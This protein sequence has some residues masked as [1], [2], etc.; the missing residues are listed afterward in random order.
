LQETAAETQNRVKTQRSQCP[1]ATALDIFG[2]RWTLVLV[3]DLAMG[4]GKARFGDFL[5]SPERIPTNILTE[6][7]ARLEEHGVVAKRAYQA[8]P[9]RYEYALTRKGAELAPVL[10][11]ICVWSNA[12][13]PQTWRAPEHFLALK[14]SD[15]V[16]DEPSG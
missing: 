1:I 6:R 7:L 11:A 3:R 9:T 5:K 8:H 2:D 14:A 16:A 10:Q 15:I 12:H 13:M 4:R